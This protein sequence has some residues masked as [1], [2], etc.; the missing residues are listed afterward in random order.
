MTTPNDLDD[1][2]KCDLSP[3]LSQ[4]SD[5]NAPM[6]SGRGTKI[7]ADARGAYI[8]GNLRAIIGQMDDSKQLRFRQVVIGQMLAQIR[9]VYSP[10]GTILQTILVIERWVQQPTDPNHEAVI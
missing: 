3:M 2:S 5:D 7:I 6:I 8:A 9:S 1:L 10:T 4:P